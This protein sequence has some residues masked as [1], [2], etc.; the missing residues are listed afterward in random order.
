MD[1]KSMS[2]PTGGIPPR[3]AQWCKITLLINVCV[4]L[5]SLQVYFS[6]VTENSC[7]AMS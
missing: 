7:K 6:E 4:S 5:M 1:M 3:D 2:R